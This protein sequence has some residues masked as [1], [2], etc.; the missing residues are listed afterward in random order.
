MSMMLIIGVFG[1]PIRAAEIIVKEDLKSNLEYVK[2]VEETICSIENGNTEYILVKVE[3]WNDVTN[4]ILFDFSEQ[5]NENNFSAIADYMNENGIAIVKGVINLMPNACI[6]DGCP[7]AG[8]KTVTDSNSYT[9][10]NPN[11]PVTLTATVTFS[12]KCYV[13]SSGAFVNWDS[14]N[15]S[16]SCSR[17]PSFGYESL[18]LN[19]I[20]FDFSSSIAK[21]TFTLY[22]TYNDGL[23][24]G[25]YKIGTY[26]ITLQS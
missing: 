24:I 21:A 16:L 8:I 6:G 9:Y 3:N 4:E 11:I 13:Q 10:R 25:S 1:K 5:I 18:S 2:K 20:S 22:T 7:T 19:N 26:T 17:F 14:A 12:A 15:S 23:A